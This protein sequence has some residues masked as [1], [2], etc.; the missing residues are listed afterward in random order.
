MTKMYGFELVDEQPVA[1][2]A[3]VARLWR[4]TVTGAQ[5]LSMVN[6]DENKVFGVSFRTP[7]TDSTGV[8]HILEH[9]VLCGSEKYPVKEPF[10]ELLKGS[11]Q[12]FLNA[13][14][15]PDKT[16]YPVAST[17]LQDFYNLVDVYLDACFFPRIT[18][19]IFQQEGWHYEVDGDAKRLSYKGVVFNEMKGVYSSPDSVLGEQSQQSLFPD[20][21]YGL[22][23]G[24][25]PTAIPDL[26]YE[27]FHTFHETYYHPSN[28]RFYFWGDDPEEERLAILGKLLDRFGPLKVDSAVPLQ[29]AFDAPRSAVVGYAAGPAQDEESRR[30]MFT[31]NWLLPETV[32]VELNFAFQML[33]HILIGM[34]ASPLRKVLIESGLGEDIAGVGLESELRQMYF[35]TGLKGIDPEDA[36]KVEALI[37]DTLRELAEK[38]IDPACVEA[39]VN[40]VEFSL[41]ENNTGRF[42]VGLAVMVRSLSTW[43]YDGDPLALL[44]F[45]APLA[46][47]KQRLAAGER[48]FEELVTCAFLTNNHRSTV[49]LVPDEKLQE[50]R[51]QEEEGRL[52]AVRESLDGRSLEA[53]EVMAEDL[54]TMQE[55]PD[56]PEAVASIPRVTKDDL[57][58][59]NKTIPAEFSEVSGVRVMTHDLPTGGIL[60]ADVTFDMLGVDEAM[61]PY[62]P[63]LARCFTEMGTAKRDFVELG[64]RIAAKT[65]GIEG[66]MLVTTAL[67]DR[68][69]VV[70][71]LVN[72]K[73]TVDNA[74]ALFSLLG[75]VLLEGQLDDKERFRSI[76]LEEKARAEEQLVPAGHSVVISRLRSH[77]GVA[78]WVTELTDGIAYLQ[79]LR[80]M[81]SSFEVEWP[82][83]LANLKAVREMLVRRN[84]ALMNITVDD[85]GWKN[86]LPHAEA[87]LASLPERESAGA[88]WS[89]SAAMLHEAF[90]IPAQVNYVGKA[91]NLYEL[92]YTYHGSA[93]VIFKHLRMGWLWDKVRVQGGAYGAFAAFDRASGTLAQVSYRDPNL[94]KTLDVYDAS[95]EYLRN[96]NLS[97]DELEKAIVGAIGE[98]DAHLL[99]DA[100]G[101]ASMAR[102]FTGDTEERR[103]QMRDEILSTSVD[104]FRAFGAILSEAANKGIVCVLG[105]A[106][107]K[108]A[109]ADKGWQLAE[110]L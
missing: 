97:A 6:S 104:D 22:D 40:T 46:A 60:Y 80:R 14:T 19:A 13:F 107:V 34:P 100:K 82:N 76:L 78:G 18:E 109:A 72:A 2:L 93:N 43:L 20:I 63:L 52:A 95:A 89:F 90:A 5:L 16:C 94:L 8:A 51:K 66:D 24:G 91:A 53:I 62:V 9:S 15:Y 74:E 50:V 7:P 61:L 68:A 92:G 21:T 103:Q 23:S 25:N 70:K 54:R 57:P 86:V 64:M 33:E 37:F 102:Y 36:P 56:D 58:L 28:G 55:T 88:A 11:L 67:Q 1:E 39:A 12:T 3:S 98:L 26:T 35:S 27:Q 17:N 99:P 30:G 71:L 42:P 45:E 69:P 31:V 44:A 101:A 108:E 4:H 29:P 38:G 49:L 81:A 48:V 110:L 41:R 59:K 47:I 84:G 105:G 79:F 87:F 83:I 32:E 96:V 73:A 85:A 106:G 10:V 77:F 65:G 75:E